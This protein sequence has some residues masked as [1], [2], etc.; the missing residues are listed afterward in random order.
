MR[1]A[2]ILATHG[3]AALAVR[4][5]LFGYPY[6]WLVQLVRGDE[7]PKD[8]GAQIRLVLEKLGPTFIKFGQMLSTRVDLLPMDVA[9]E[10]KRLQDDVPPEPFVRVKRVIE[11]SFKCPLT[12]K[13]GLFESFE[14]KSVAAAS[15]A[16]VHFAELKGG[17]KVAV[18]VRRDYIGRIIEADLAILYLLASLFERYFP[19]YRR[20]KAPR[21]I[22]EFATTIRGE[23]NLRAEAAHASRFAENL[24][25]V[26]GVRV[27]EVL[28]DY[29]RTEV[30][31]TERI[32][33][34]PI[35]EKEA[36]QSAGHNCLQL[37]ERTAILFF[38]TVFIDGYFHGDMHPGNIFVADN[39][40]IILVDFGIVGRLDI[41]TRR[42]LADMMMAFLKEDY[43]RAAEVHV[44]AGYVPADTNV[45][46][47]EDALREI[48]IPI[49]N[50]PLGD[51]SI[52]ELLLAMFAVTERF[53]ME[54]QPELLLLQKTMV[55]I[56]GVARELADHANIWE[57]ARPLITEWV[58]RHMGPV[59][60]AE[61]LADELRDQLH[62]WM[63]LPEQL[64]AV[65]ARVESGEVVFA[66]E[67]SRLPVLAGA[68]LAATG[69]A[70]LAASAVQ[71][72]GSWQLVS[73]ALV[74]SLGFILSISR[75]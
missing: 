23:L 43:R 14:E 8:L 69:G 16:Q 55:V 53:K 1:I 36:L 51:I 67:S 59:G 7:L 11:D 73:S 57:L 75:S 49:F 65:M 31:T 26:E 29:T 35:D 17:R 24:A 47:F 6:V 50:R 12:G 34:I 52:A 19:E 56:E 33:G 58:T 3:M 64:D 25:D 45:S 5:R 54:T 66:S 20:L 72:A 63:K 10:L 30:L 74:M 41:K 37:C 32:S 4:L 71:G 28:W 9:L 46:A 39:G 62:G 2:H 18:K 21:V 13:N 42:Y 27:P 40:E 48:A 70:W 68:V 38:H 22:D 60:R 15:I 61:A 44:E